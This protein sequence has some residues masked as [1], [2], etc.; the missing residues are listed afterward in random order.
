M[1]KET[2]YVAESVKLLNDCVSIKKSFEIGEIAKKLGTIG[3]VGVL[4]FDVLNMVKGHLPKEDPLAKELRKLGTQIE[5]LSE[6]TS[7]HFD[8]LK[9][10]ITEHDIIR[11]VAVPTAVRMRL[12]NDVMQNPNHDSIGSF[13]NVCS[14][15]TPKDI[16]YRFIELLKN[17]V[18]NPLKMAL[19]KD[20]LR[21]RATFNKWKQFIETVFGQILFMEYQV[22]GMFWGNNGYGPRKV[23]EVM[24]EVQGL[25][26]IWQK[27]YEK[28]YW[29]TVVEKLIWKIQRENEH[30]GNYERAEMLQDKMNDVLSN[31]SFGILV[32]N[33]CAGF[34]H[35][36]YCYQSDN[37]ILSFRYG[38]CNI[39]VL[40]SLL[41][42]SISDNERDQFE[43]GMVRMGEAGLPM[44]EDYKGYPEEL[45]NKYVSNW[46]FMGMVAFNR[47]LHFRHANMKHRAWP[48]YCAKVPVI[49]QQR[50]PMGWL[51]PSWEDEFCDKYGE[52]YWILG[53]YL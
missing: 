12:L 51:F 44:K 9:A 22:D 43:N 40:R 30:T 27:E 23:L 5:R 36:S 52:Y 41:W 38:K 2:Q 39:V 49:K 50:S 48:G 18:T 33:D 8:E 53:G 15:T 7:Q 16:A 25:L 34:D 46:G 28:S 42:N 47:N 4:I 37:A 14:Q 3:A 35:H 6:E 45:A 13:K 24:N 21:K 10:F 26:I 20:E 32:Y 11:D 31:D 29:S 19:E 1:S 17:K